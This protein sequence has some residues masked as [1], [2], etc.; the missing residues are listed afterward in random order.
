[1]LKEHNYVFKRVNM[2]IDL[3]LTAG[4]VLIAHGL[5][6]AVLAPWLFPEVFRKPAHLSDYWWLVY[7]LPIFMVFFLRHFGYYQSQRIRSFGSTMGAVI[8]SAIWTSIVAMVLSFILSE[9]GSR[10]APTDSISGENVSRGVLLLVPIVL[11]VLMAIK[12]LAVRQFL[13]SV[14]RRGRN[15][16]SLLLVGSGESLREFIELVQGHPFW[17]FLIAGVID[18]SGRESKAVERVPVVGHLN[19][20]VAF[21]EKTP[22]DEVVFIPARRSLE[23][24]APY[25][26][27]C[28]EMGIRTRLSLT[29][30]RGTIAKPVL[31]AFE[32]IPVVTYSPTAELNAALLF[33]YAFDRV[34]AAILLALASPFML[35]IALLVKA[36]SGSWSDPV[37][38]GQE[39][40]GL[41][42]KPFTLWK[43]RSM[44][45]NADKE[46][47]QLQQQN[48]MQGPVFKIKND[49]RMTSVGKWL[50]KTSLDELPQLWNVL[51]GDMSLVGPRPPLPS[52]VARYDRWQRRRLSMKPGITCLW[53]VMGRNQLSFDT[54]M[55]LDLEYIDRWS[56][57]LDFQILC[58]TV[59][60][61]A[62]GYGAM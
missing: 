39:R 48:E 23:D 55:K 43:F 37:F 40:S 59:Y 3:V 18:D 21:L 46:L 41:H 42:G 35:V 22:V 2:A 10:P 20:L 12:T 58:R 17:G 62:T 24:L 44:R 19:N 60:V 15:S 6:N 34:A 16:R 25:F 5:R 32:E 4:S 38:Y 47:A 14:R 33:K 56:L 49:P 31:D 30:F 50:R 11:T 36:T 54:W 51:C 27:A 1:M 52:E 53:Q 61:V 28:E 45:V 8:V 9:R 57:W 7:T 29:F 26:G 13:I